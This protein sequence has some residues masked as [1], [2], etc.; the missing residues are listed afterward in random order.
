MTRTKAKSDR[1]CNRLHPA[2]FIVQRW[3][4]PFS[5]LPPPETRPKPPIPATC[6]SDLRDPVRP[7][8]RDVSVHAFVPDPRPWFT[9]AAAP[10]GVRFRGHVPLAVIYSQRL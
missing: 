9:T 6:L 10:V 2:D 1:I 4:P 8:R 7:A 3:D 5:A